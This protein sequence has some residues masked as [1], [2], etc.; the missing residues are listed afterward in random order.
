MFH[1]E[2]NGFYPLLI[3]LSILS[4][5]VLAMFILESVIFN[6]SIHSLDNLEENYLDINIKA[7][8]S[9]NFTTTLD[10]IYSP[11]KDNLG[12][13]GTVMYDCYNGICIKKVTKYCYER[14]QDSEGNWY[15]EEVDCSYNIEDFSFDCSRYC[16][17]HQNSETCSNCPGTSEEGRCERNTNDNY[18]TEK[19]CHADN[20][21][22]NWKGKQYI[23]ETKSHFTYL[24]NVIL[25]NETCPYNYKLCGIVDKFNNKLCIS[26]Y[27]DCPLN[28]L[29][30]IP[31]IPENISNATYSFVIIDNNTIKID[32]KNENGKIIEGLYADSDLMIQY[33]EDCELIDEDKIS[34]FIQ[35]NKYLYRDVLENDPYT[36]VNI[37]RHG[38]SYLKW[39]TQN[40]GKGNSLLD[41]RENLFKYQYN[42]SINEGTLNQTKTYFKNAFVPI[43]F[44]FFYYFCFAVFYVISLISE[45]YGNPICIICSSCFISDYDLLNGIYFTLSLIPYI[46]LTE[47]GKYVK[48]YFI[49]DNL[50]MASK[51]ANPDSNIMKTLI[52]LNTAF[53]WGTNV[54][55]LILLFII[56]YGAIIQ[57]SFNKKGFNDYI[58]QQNKNE[59]KYKLTNI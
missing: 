19:S 40:S 3:I 1:P 20:L 55:Y 5:L 58:S 36:D 21:I 56:I 9:F 13:A 10:N 32:N 33:N 38:K 23:S 26:Y 4:L 7:L 15:T 35:D 14:K 44:A 12:T 49:K 31:G 24:K 27:D 59:N 22:L 29:E 6:K 54:I 48:I 47:I 16:R 28:N 50:L 53:Y 46:I 17:E 45:I 30:I 8:K 39:C 2:D 42:I 25:P 57:F 43:F 52:S 41:L 34:S 37:D 51:Y 18:Q 11:N